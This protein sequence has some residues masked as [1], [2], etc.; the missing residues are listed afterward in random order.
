[1]MAMPEVMA[2]LSPFTGVRSGP[3]N[4]RKAKDLAF[5]ATNAR[6][7]SGGPGRQAGEG[8]RKPR[9]VVLP[10]IRPFGAPSPRK[11]GEGMALP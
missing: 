4:G 9:R 11:R 8:R 2:L 1:M 3:R 5:R 7:H 6:S 10:L